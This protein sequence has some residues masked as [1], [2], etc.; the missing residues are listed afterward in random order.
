[1]KHS[2]LMAGCIAL[3]ML[4]GSNSARAQTQ[5]ELNQSAGRDLEAAETRM[6][7]VLA[8]LFKMANGRPKAVAKLEQAQSAWRSYRDAHVKAYWPSD[9][10]GQYGSVYP[11]CVA[12]EMTRLTNARIADLQNMTPRGEG[13]VC[14]CPWPE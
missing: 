2:L 4:S 5:L 7:E 14:A 11:M 3:C 12:L 6:N 10:L 8:R 13:D 9:D 1:M